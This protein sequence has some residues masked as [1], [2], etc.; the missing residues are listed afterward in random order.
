[1]RL[2][3]CG[4]LQLKVILYKIILIIEEIIGSLEQGRVS[5]DLQILIF[6]IRLLNI[7]DYFV[8]FSVKISKKKMFEKQ[9]GCYGNFVKLEDRIFFQLLEFFLERSQ[10]YVVILGCFSQDQYRYDEILIL[11][12]IW[13]GEGLFFLQ[14]YVIVYY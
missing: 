3:L 5:V 6:F 7:R 12:V 1:M 9:R 13:G 2:L 8:K 11:K 10:V 4:K 14:F